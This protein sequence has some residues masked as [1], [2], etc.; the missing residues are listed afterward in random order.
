MRHVLDRFLS[1]EVDLVFTGHQRW[2]LHEMWS[3]K[4]Q[5]NQ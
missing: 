5:K 4:S 3:A 1:L 2:D